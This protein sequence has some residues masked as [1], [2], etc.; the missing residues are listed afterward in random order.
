MLIATQVYKFTQNHWT[1]HLKWWILWSVN[2]WKQWGEKPVNK[3]VERTDTS[4]VR[5]SELEDISKYVTQNAIQRYNDMKLMKERIR[6]MEESERVP[7]KSKRISGEAV[8]GKYKG[9]E[10][11]RSDSRYKTSD[12]GSLVNLKQ[13]KLIHLYTHTIMKQQK[14][15]KIL[16]AMRRTKMIYRTKLEPKGCLA[17]SLGGA[18]DS[19]TQGHEVQAP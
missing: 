18:W 5:S 16:R 15:K 14:W 8:L 1:V 19:W 11:F 2:Y 3:W 13:E 12:S 10:L 4:E 7:Q 9:W 17:G 6:D